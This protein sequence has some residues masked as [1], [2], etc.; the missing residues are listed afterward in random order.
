M[1][2]RRISRPVSRCARSALLASSGR[3]ASLRLALALALALPGFGEDGHQP[4]PSDVHATTTRPPNIVAPSS[5]DTPT[6][7]SSLRE[8]LRQREF[9]RLKY[10]SRAL[11]GSLT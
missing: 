2:T 11:T 8:L 5:L 10:Y 1:T 4:Q 7:M 9:T 3:G 6:G